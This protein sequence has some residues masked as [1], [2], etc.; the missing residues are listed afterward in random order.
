MRSMELVKLGT[1]GQL[2]IPKSIL[3][4]TGISDEAPLLI[5]TTNE[6]AIIL[7]QA[8]V[9]PIELYSEARI[10]EFEKLNTVP[11]ALEAR[12]ETFLRK[13]KKR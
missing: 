6:G 7:R 8:G 3:K 5:E 12:V 13:K 2:T 11:P 9:Y 1:K 10:R 4:A